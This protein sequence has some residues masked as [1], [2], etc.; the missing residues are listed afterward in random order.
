MDAAAAVAQK[1]PQSD[2]LPDD[3]TQRSTGIKSS[4]GNDVWKPSAGRSL[5]HALLEKRRPGILEFH[6]KLKTG[7]IEEMPFQETEEPVDMEAAR[8]SWRGEHGKVAS[9]FLPVDYN[10]G[11]TY[12]GR[13]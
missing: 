11:F 2:A 8:K 12:R 5:V 6:E 13:E 4:I 10:C 3:P 9:V 7:R 1:A